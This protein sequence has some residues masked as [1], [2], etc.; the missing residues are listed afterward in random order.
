MGRE[1]HFIPRFLLKYFSVDANG[2]LINVHLLNE[3]RL[4]KGAS[5]K[6]QAQRHYLYGMDQKLEKFYEQLE[7]NTASVIRK[8]STGFLYLNNEENLHLKLF[9]H[10]QMNRTPGN[11]ELFNNSIESIIK[12]MASYN[13]KLKNHLNEFAIGINNPYMF[14]FRLA[15]KA[16]H[17]IMNLRIGL[18]GSSNKKPFIIGQNPVV[19]LNPFLK[20][21]NWQWSTQG[22]ILKGIMII[23][24]ISPQFSVI[25]YD[26]LCYTLINKYPNWIISDNDI[27]L[28]NYLQYLNTKEC[29]YFS[30]DPDITY[31]NSISDKTKN[32]R[33]DVKVKLNLLSKRVKDDG[34]IE[35]IINSGLKEYPIEQNFNFYSLKYDAYMKQITNHVQARREVMP[36][37]IE[38]E[39]NR[40]LQSKGHST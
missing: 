3:N 24:P 11:V 35:E 26:S 10:Y 14:L 21:K 40:R 7:G 25:M 2:K 38:D 13:K 17:V 6:N 8:L 36:N 37:F 27:D 5:L 29:I 4:S 39:I 22:L 31:F 28:L 15:T 16:L 34:E 23:M 12:N 19:R 32:F 18:L 20:A 1:Q 9:I 33:N 30:Y